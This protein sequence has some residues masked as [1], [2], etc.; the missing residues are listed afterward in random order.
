MGDLG[1]EKYFPFSSAAPGAA[2]TLR[3]FLNNPK[4][5]GSRYRTLD[6]Q[7]RFNWRRLQYDETSPLHGKEGVQLR[8]Y[9]R[10]IG[11]RNDLL[12]TEAA[13]T[14][15]I[16]PNRFLPL[17]K[18][19]IS[20]FIMAGVGAYYGKPKADLIRGSVDISHRYFFWNDG[21][22]RDLPQKIG[23]AHV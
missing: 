11:F 14:Y 20:F 16:Y 23:R 17:W 5:S 8:N 22:V 15:N 21:T 18:P 4:N 12:G 7:I 13:L 3:N 19:K 1:N 9:L 10:G 2:V 6:L